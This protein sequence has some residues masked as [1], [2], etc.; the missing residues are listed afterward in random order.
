MP[1]LYPRI[2]LL[3]YEWDDG[4]RKA[5][6]YWKVNDCSCRA[7]AIATGRS[8]ADVYKELTEY[9]WS[10]ESKRDLDK[11]TK[12][13]GG[14]CPRK[15]S[16]EYVKAIFSEILGSKYA[17]IPRI[18]EA[19]MGR[20]ARFYDGHLF[21]DRCVI[22]LRDHVAAVVDGKIRDTWD[23]RYSPRLTNDTLLQRLHGRSLHPADL[24]YALV[25]HEGKTQYT[26]LPKAIFGYWV[27][28]N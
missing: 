9:G 12:W 27:V 13:P 2:R 26:W 23:C 16:P 7:V 18:V 10:T 1:S 5:A 25:G 4:G 21:P 24:Q 8:Y 19:G 22:K 14:K 15:S 3:G 11:A 28:S 6:G 17:S 20:K